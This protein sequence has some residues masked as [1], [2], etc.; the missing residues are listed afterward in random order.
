MSRR[1]KLLTGLSIVAASTAIA[2]VKVEYDH[3]ADFSQYRSFAWKPGRLLVDNAIT[4]PEAIDAA[5]RAKL[6]EAITERGGELVAENPDVYV[7]YHLG[8]Q[9]HAA[10]RA[11]PTYDYMG[12]W[13]YTVTP[14]WGPSWSE[15]M[16]DQ[17]TEG[18]L[19]LD[20]IDAKTNTLV[21]RAFCNKVVGA[22][23]TNGKK[24]DQCVRQFNRKY[25]PKAKR[26]RKK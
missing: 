19:V 1:L 18:T 2:G 24:L 10:V 3:D 8:A 4:P 25:P 22:P 23:G 7:T 26:N 6:T 14:Y 15:V 9:E 16:V 20:V 12:Y 17:W 11:Y 13:G 21:W 5:I